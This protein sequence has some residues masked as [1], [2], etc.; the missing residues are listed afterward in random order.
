M[1]STPRR[2]ASPTTSG[3]IGSEPWAPVPMISR[4]PPQGGSS[5]ADTGVCPNS[6]RYGF[7]GFF[8]RFRTRPPSMMMSLSY[9]RPRPQWIRTG[10]VVPACRHLQVWPAGA[11]HRWPIV[12]NPRNDQGGDR[13]GAASRRLRRTT[14]GG[15]VWALWPRRR[16]RRPAPVQAARPWPMSDCTVPRRRASAQSR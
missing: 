9:S 1:R 8:F 13:G 6:S 5:S 4:P 11:A 10:V 3:M 7:D 16:G 14:A 15:R 2:R 12:R